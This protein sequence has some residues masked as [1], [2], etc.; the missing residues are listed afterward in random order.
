MGD[1]L[2]CVRQTYDQQSEKKGKESI[3]LNILHYNLG[4]VLMNE[5][6]LSNKG[7]QDNSSEGLR[8]WC[9]RGQRVHYS[10]PFS[11]EAGAK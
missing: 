10:K 1:L 7:I 4:R 8:G 6:L 3:Y 11:G 9:W 5:S 2:F